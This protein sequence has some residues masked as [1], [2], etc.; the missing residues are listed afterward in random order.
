[1]RVSAVV[2]AAGA[3]QRFGPGQN[4]LLAQWRG[5]AL[6][7]Y[8]L[9]AA[10]N[11]RL[12]GAVSEV[13][14]VTRADATR[15]NSIAAGVS[16][17][18]VH[19]P[20]DAPMSSSL[21]TAVAAVDPAAEGIVLLLGDQPM[22]TGSMVAAL[23]EVAARSGQGLVRAHFR[24]FADPVSHPAF[25]ASRHFGL[26]H[27]LDADTGFSAAVTRLGLHW[28]EL[29]FDGDNPDVDY[30]ADLERLR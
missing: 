11:A 16:S 27:Q 30:P 4:K 9:G 3:S 29:P 13:V 14:V 2:L 6:I 18:V 19:P 28:L 10:L 7:E 17:R 8:A 24:G 15:L 23:V 5:R 1:M 12:A 20:A 25:V 21:K 22:V 26:I